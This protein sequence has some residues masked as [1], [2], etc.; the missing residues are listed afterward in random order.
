MAT[1]AVLPSPGGAGSD[2]SFGDGTAA[3]AARLPRLKDDEPRPAGQ[4]APAAG[5]GR[6]APGT[7]KRAPHQ[8]ATRARWAGL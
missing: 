7:A 5:G 6:A 1:P 2:A 4:R 8:S 3:L